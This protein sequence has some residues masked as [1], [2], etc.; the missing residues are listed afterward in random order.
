MKN[1]ILCDALLISTFHCSYSVRI[2]PTAVLNI[3]LR[4]LGPNVTALPLSSS[5]LLSG[6]NSAI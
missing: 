1:V 6:E 2:R 5:F 3:V 4:K